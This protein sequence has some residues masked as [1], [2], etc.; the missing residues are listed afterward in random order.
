M[1]KTM[2][3]ILTLAMA[4]VIAI[5][6]TACEKVILGKE[7]IKYKSQLDAVTFLNNS[8][9][10]VAIIDSVMAGYYVTTGEFAN[11][12]MI[13]PELTLA[14]E[15]YG[16]AGKKGNNA[17]LSKVNEGLIALA[18][19]AI[20]DTATKYGLKNELLI[21]GTTVNPYANATDSSWSNL[22]KSKKVVIGITIFAPIA[23]YD[24]GNKLVGFDIEIAEAVF[25]YL[26]EQASTKIEIEFLPI[27]W[28]N[29]EA[30]L[31]KGDIDLVWNGLTITDP[32]LNDMC[33]SLPYLANKQVAVIKKADKDTYTDKDS[34]MNATIGVEA[35]SAGEEVVIKK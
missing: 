35:G 7:V 4:S 27:E 30:M 17:L 22:L 14:N 34:L 6:A 3:I 25:A 21:S 10:D 28:D 19:T 13:I 31:A 33:I 23:F 1:K 24:V 9:V 12:L 8:T 26:A 11:N 16:I 5:M 15:Q 20:A 18:D 29:K 2:R 32:R